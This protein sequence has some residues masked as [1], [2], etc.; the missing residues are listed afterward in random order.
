MRGDLLVDSGARLNVR[1]R[2]RTLEKKELTD[3]FP[4]AL[5]RR[6]RVAAARRT[7]LGGARVLPGERLRQRQAEGRR[8]VLRERARGVVEVRDDAGRVQARRDDRAR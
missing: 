2:T 4:S 8:R 5:P 6:A 3:G 1:S 7:R